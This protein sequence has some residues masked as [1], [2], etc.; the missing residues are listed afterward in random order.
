MT[1]ALVALGLMV[2]LAWLMNLSWGP[3]KRCGCSNPTCSR[4]PENR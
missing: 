4:K 1:A 2:V 3:P